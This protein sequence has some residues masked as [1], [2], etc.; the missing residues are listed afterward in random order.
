MNR[1][2]IRG[3]LY[4]AG[5]GLPVWAFLAAFISIGLFV[6]LLI[7]GMVCLTVAVYIE[8]TDGYEDTPQGLEHRGV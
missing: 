6:G 1:N 3:A 8:D 5:F 2:M 4:S 7:A